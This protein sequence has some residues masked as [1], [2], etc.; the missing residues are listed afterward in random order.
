MGRTRYLRSMTDEKPKKPLRV[1]R[2]GEERPAPPREP[3]RK[4]HWK[5]K[6]FAPVAGWR[7]WVRDWY[8]EG[9][10]GVAWFPVAGFATIEGDPDDF[11][12]PMI[13]QTHE[14]FHLGDPRLIDGFFHLSPPTESPSVSEA[15][16]HEQKRAYERWF[17]YLSKHYETQRRCG[18]RS[19]MDALCVVIRQGLVGPR[20]R[21][22]NCECH[23]VANKHE[24][25]SDE[26]FSLWLSEG[27]RVG[28][29]PIDDD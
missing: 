9:E 27:N 15:I 12:V 14:G 25:M 5:I 26:Q 17:A 18:C 10:D 20:R 6:S 16:A 21:A 28:G 8:D 7:A 3:A 24:E 4:V 23:G 13:V 1:V 29:G 11:V 22:C 19:H 2:S